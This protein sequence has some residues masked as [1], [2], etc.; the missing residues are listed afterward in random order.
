MAK[1]LEYKLE[2]DIPPPTRFD[3][4]SPEYVAMAKMKPGD[5]FEFPADRANLVQNTRTHLIREFPERAYM[6]TNQKTIEINKL[7]VGRCWRLTDGSTRKYAK[8]KTTK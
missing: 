1:Q 8:R 3:K 4:G 6:A 5:S 7:K 2:K